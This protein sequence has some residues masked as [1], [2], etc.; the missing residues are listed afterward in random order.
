MFSLMTK[1]YYCWKKTADLST[2]YQSIKQQLIMGLMRTLQVYLCYDVYYL[3]LRFCDL[4]LPST[5]TG[6][7][8]MTR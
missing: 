7:F 2:R 8:A 6:S 1:F 3:L 4:L 5:S